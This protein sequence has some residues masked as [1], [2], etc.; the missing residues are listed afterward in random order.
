ML[1][2]LLRRI[3]QSALVLVVM[4]LIVFLGVYAIGN[5]IELLVNPQ[6]DEIERSRATI[7]LGLDKTL[8][9]QYWV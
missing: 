8:Y 5:P 4:S 9:E 1:A 6:A 3:S 7:A 2:Y